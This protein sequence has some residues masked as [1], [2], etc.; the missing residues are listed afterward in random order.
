MVKYHSS[1]IQVMKRVILL[2]IY[3]VKL[4]VNLAE[5]SQIS[6]DQNTEMSQIVDQ[7]FQN[8]SLQLLPSRLIISTLVLALKDSMFKESW[9]LLNK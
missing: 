5:D 7:A 9:N 4:Q 6:S 1:G 3:F 8:W 2:R